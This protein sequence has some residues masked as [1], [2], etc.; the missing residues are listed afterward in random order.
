MWS[1]GR[2]APC[3][4][5]DCVAATSIKAHKNAIEHDF[6]MF[7]KPM[8]SSE[9]LVQLAQCCGHRMKGRLR[10]VVPSLRPSL[11]SFTWINS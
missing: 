1:G 11:L 10:A 8:R 3:W 6:P 7:S 2:A 5:T 9:F 4:L